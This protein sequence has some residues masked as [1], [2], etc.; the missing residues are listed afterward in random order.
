MLGSGK[1]AKTFVEESNTAGRAEVGN[2][3]STELNIEHAVFNQPSAA[4][5]VVD[6]KGTKITLAH[7]SGHEE[8]RE[9]EVEVKQVDP[10][11][12]VDELKEQMETEDPNAVV[13]KA[14]DCGTVNKNRVRTVIHETY[15]MQRSIELEGNKGPVCSDYEQMY[16]QGMNKIG[17]NRVRKAVRGSKVIVLA[18]AA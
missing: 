6:D 13:L 12:D 2:G 5:S 1:D 8:A 11:Q 3:G 17:L 10:D 16:N 14:E 15:A 4:G 9:F 7:E 18:L